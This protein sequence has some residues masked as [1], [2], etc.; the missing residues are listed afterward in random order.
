MSAA[1]LEHRDDRAWPKGAAPVSLLVGLAVVAAG[2]VMTTGSNH[3]VL[4]ALCLLFGLTVGS[5]LIV[6]GISRWLGGQP[7]PSGL[8][9]V[10]LLIGVAGLIVS[11][12][13][14]FIG[15]GGTLLMGLA[16]GL[17]LAN[18]WAI[19]AARRNRRPEPSTRPGAH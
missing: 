3:V 17:L 19:R 2:I 12:L 13:F 16:G 7:I 4:A 9:V 8:G 14:G 5:S 1:Q 15:P 18:V 6:V 11:R 10:S